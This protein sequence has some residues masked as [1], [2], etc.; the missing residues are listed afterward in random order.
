MAVIRVTTTTVWNIDTEA[1]INAA[2][3][4]DA[5]TEGEA[6]EMRADLDHLGEVA[7]G[8]SDAKDHLPRWA[9]DTMRVVSTTSTERIT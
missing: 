6:R 5:L 8:Y 2:L 7:T 1:Y 4:A 9:R 3:E